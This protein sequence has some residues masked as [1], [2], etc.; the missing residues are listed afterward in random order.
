M[1]NICLKAVQYI[2]NTT[3]GKKVSMF[4]VPA[5]GMYLIM[6]FYSIPR[7]LEYSGGMKI[8]DLMPTGYNTEYGQKLFETLGETGREI[9]SKYT[10]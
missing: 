5:M 10:S 6:F 9:Y 3:S 4:L 1:I 7:V 2:R 8:L